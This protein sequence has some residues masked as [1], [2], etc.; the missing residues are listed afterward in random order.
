MGDRNLSATWSS[1]S[2]DTLNPYEYRREPRLSTL[3]ISP[4]DRD[5]RFVAEPL[6]NSASSD[7][8]P[9]RFLMG[10]RPRPKPSSTLGCRHIAAVMLCGR[11][12]QRSGTPN[13]SAADPRST[14][15]SKFSIAQPTMLAHNAPQ[16]F[17][18]EALR[19]PAGG[20]PKVEKTLENLL[21][22][23]RR[24]KAGFDRPNLSGKRTETPR[25]NSS[26]A[27]SVKLFSTAFSR[28]SV[29][30]QKEA[31]PLWTHCFLSFKP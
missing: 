3:P 27:A 15:P 20:K 19:I 1:L 18:V 21:N 2:S 6:S 16:A 23:C 17:F 4:V 8:A 14:K 9:T 28:S 24:C 13:S 30:E 11:A 25:R 22:G 10:R 5:R 31:A 29:H 7:A 12:V 26:A